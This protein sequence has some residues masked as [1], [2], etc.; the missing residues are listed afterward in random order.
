MNNCTYHIPYFSLV[1]Y[2]N[3]INYAIEILMNFFRCWLFMSVNTFLILWICFLNRWHYC[4]YGSLNLRTI[5]C[6]LVG[7]EFLIYLWDMRRLIS[8]LHVGRGDSLPPIMNIQFNVQLFHC[9]SS[10]VGLIEAAC[11]FQQELGSFLRNPFCS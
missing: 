2:D 8:S 7:A 4:V 10:I 6:A 9:L 1:A 3:I 11:A 5:G